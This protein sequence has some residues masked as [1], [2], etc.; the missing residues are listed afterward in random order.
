M[1]TKPLPCSISRMDSITRSSIIH[2]RHH[3]RA[4]THSQSPQS[5]SHLEQVRALLVD[6]PVRVPRRPSASCVCD[7]RRPFGMILD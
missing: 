1:S 5:I 4:Q 3:H 2:T 7:G 6:E